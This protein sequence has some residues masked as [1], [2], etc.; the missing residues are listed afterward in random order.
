MTH[1]PK[2]EVN[3]NDLASAVT[4]DLDDEIWAH[5]TAS[6]TTHEPRKEGMTQL[7]EFTTRI[8]TET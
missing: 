3:V 1:G 2:K 5:D 8:D 7:Q 6:I 4:H